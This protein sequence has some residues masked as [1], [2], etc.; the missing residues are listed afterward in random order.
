MTD[1][2]KKVSSFSIFFPLDTLYG[3]VRNHP[4]V[5]LDY[6]LDILLIYKKYEGRKMTVPVRRHAYVR[7][8]YVTMLY[9]EDPLDSSIF[10]KL[11]EKYEML[12]EVQKMNMSTVPSSESSKSTHSLFKRIL[13][14]FNGADQMPTINGENS[15]PDDLSHQWGEARQGLEPLMVNDKIQSKVI[16]FVVPLT[17]RWE[18]FVN[19]MRN[20]EE[21]CLKSGEKTRLVVVLFENEHTEKIGDLKQSQAILEVFNRLKK[22]YDLKDNKQALNLLINTGI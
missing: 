11:P 5:G 20:Y 13:N 1:L 19:F 21:V 7:N 4:L 8:S 14:L 2:T 12:A 18:V 15:S 3:Y 10:Y 22:D 9:R 6:I 16:N 17:G